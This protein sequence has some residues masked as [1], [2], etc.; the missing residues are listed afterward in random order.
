MHFNTRYQGNGDKSSTKL[1]CHT[2]FISCLCSR[3]ENL[4]ERTTNC[5]NCFRVFG[6]SYLERTRLGC[7]IQRCNP[8]TVAALHAT[9]RIH[10]LCLGHRKTVRLLI[11]GTCFLL[12]FTV[13]A[14]LDR[15][16]LL[17]TMLHSSISHNI[18]LVSPAVG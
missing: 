1:G 18:S 3:R 10:M 5:D 2:F 7:T 6:S 14:L 16:T 12:N 13:A 15:R 4:I 17:L 8:H 11:A 9:S